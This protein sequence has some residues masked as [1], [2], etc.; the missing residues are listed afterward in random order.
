M[1]VGIFNAFHFRTFQYAEPK[2]QILLI[3]THRSFYN[4]R[5]NILPHPFESS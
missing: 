1:V 4:E 3:A 2:L 5:W